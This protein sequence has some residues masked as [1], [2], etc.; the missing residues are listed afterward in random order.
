M[1]A[2]IRLKLY[3]QQADFSTKNSKQSLQNPRKHVDFL[4]SHCKRDLPQSVW[5]LHDFRR[6]AA[7]PQ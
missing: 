4:Y 3:F 1:S 2:K 5:Q 6:G 7:F